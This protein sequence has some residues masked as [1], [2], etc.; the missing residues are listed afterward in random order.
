MILDFLGVITPAAG[1]LM[2]NPARFSRRDGEAG[3]DKKEAR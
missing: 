1:L 2:R 3:A